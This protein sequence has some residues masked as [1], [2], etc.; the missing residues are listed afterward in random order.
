MNLLKLLFYISIGDDKAAK[1]EFFESGLGLWVVKT[2]FAPVDILCQYDYYKSYRE[3]V[4]RGDPAD[5]C[6]G[7]AAVD[8]GVHPSTINRAI[9]RFDGKYNPEV[10]FLSKRSEGQ[11]NKVL[12]TG[13]SETAL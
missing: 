1:F 5:K 6:I 12:R 11:K 4:E 9:K 13:A 3:H 10:R 8:C 7:L 2:G